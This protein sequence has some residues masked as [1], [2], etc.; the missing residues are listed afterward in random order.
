MEIKETNK[1]PRDKLIE[2]FRDSAFNQCENQNLQMFNV[3]KME[4]HIKDDTDPKKDNETNPL[5][6]KFEGES[7]KRFRSCSKNGDNSE[8]G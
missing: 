8:S 2:T 5:P 4:V 3:T 7:S 1:W 6:I